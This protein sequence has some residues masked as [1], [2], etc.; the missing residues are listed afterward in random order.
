VLAFADVDPA[1]ALVKSVAGTVMEPVGW[2]MLELGRSPVL[3]GTGGCDWGVTVDTRMEVVLVEL[4]LL[5]GAIEGMIV[6]SLIV[7]TTEVVLAKLEADADAVTAAADVDIA[8]ADV[9]TT[10]VDVDTAELEPVAE[11]LPGAWIWPSLIWE[12]VALFEVTEPTGLEMPNW[13]EYWYC[14]VPLTMICR[15]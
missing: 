14:P 4:A 5:M 13:V 2:T 8:A 15:P 3:T 11:V 1:V 6:G 10:E 12:T 7:E 9:D